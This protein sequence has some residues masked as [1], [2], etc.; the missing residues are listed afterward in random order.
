MPDHQK[1][2]VA[3]GEAEPAGYFAPSEGSW[4]PFADL[5]DSLVMSIFVYFTKRVPDRERAMELT[6]ETFAKAFEKRHDF[7]GATKARAASWIWSI[8][9][10]EL[11][12]FRRTNRIALEAFSRLAIDRDTDDDPSL[13]EIA[14]RSVIDQVRHGIQDVLEE[15]PPDQREVVRLRYIDELSFSE[16]A[17]TL[18]VS[19]DVV[20]ARASRATRRLKMS[21]SLRAA[22]E[23][24]DA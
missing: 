18:D 14:S 22:L 1:D 5:Y 20:R 10:T 6:A 8:A 3:Q 9:H 13:E 21:D 12:E 23:A 24:L 11:A 17:R 16:I 19:S 7:R 2:R 15:L 4:E